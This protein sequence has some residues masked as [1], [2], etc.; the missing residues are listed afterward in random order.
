MAHSDLKIRM[1][2]LLRLLFLCRGF[3]FTFFSLCYCFA[4]IIRKT[5]FFARFFP[6][7]RKG[8][9]TKWLA[10]GKAMLDAI[11]PACQIMG[12]QVLGRKHLELLATFE[13]DYLVFL[14]GFLRRQGQ[15]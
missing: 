14:Q 9:G 1:L 3:C 5:P 7:F 6:F 8:F 4:Q 11:F 2:M 15:T 10:Q 12:F 13:A